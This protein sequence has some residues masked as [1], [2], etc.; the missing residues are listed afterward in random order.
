MHDCPGDKA[1]APIPPVQSHTRAGVRMPIE[2]AHAYQGEAEQSPARRPKVGKSKKAPG[3]HL[4]RGWPKKPEKSRPVLSPIIGLLN[5]H[6]LG[7]ALT[8]ITAPGMRAPVKRRQ[9]SAALPI[10]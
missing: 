4:P 5:R 9:T 2:S 7:Q 1:S 6:V 10:R 8:L 3:C